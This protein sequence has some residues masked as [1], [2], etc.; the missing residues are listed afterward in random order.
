[1]LQTHLTKAI[2]VLQDLIALTKKDIDSMGHT[3]KQ[4]IFDHA[5]VKQQLLAKFDSLK[6]SIDLEVSSLLSSKNVELKDL[7]DERDKNL[8]HSLETKMHALKKLNKE[9][10]KQVISVGS[11]YFRLLDKLI[12]QEMNGYQKVASKSSFLNIQA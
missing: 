1:M 9:Y 11:F 6:S 12:P 10:M 7:L 8:L 4:N 3:P 2:Q 5:E